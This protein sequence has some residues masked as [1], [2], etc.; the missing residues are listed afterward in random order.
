VTLV[1]S[2]IGASIALAAAVAGVVRRRP[3]STAH[4]ARTDAHW[5]DWPPDQM[6][7]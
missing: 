1:L 5:G 7:P 6:A 3:G 2:L 4:T